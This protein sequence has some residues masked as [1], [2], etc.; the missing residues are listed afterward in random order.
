MMCHRL[1]IS[2]FSFLFVLLSGEIRRLILIALLVGSP[3]YAGNGVDTAY[4]YLPGYAGS[5]RGIDSAYVPP[6]YNK[7]FGDEF[8]T[9][10]L[11][12]TKWWT[13][14]IYAGGYLN[15]INDE[16][17]S[18]LE[19]GN[20]V[21]ENWTLYLKAYFLPDGTLSSGMLRSK[22]TFLG[23]Y[24]EASMRLP[25]A[26]GTRTAFWLNSGC[27]G[28]TTGNACSA[29]LS[30]P[31][32]IDI[33]EYIGRLGGNVWDTVGQ[34]HHSPFSENDSIMAATDPRCAVP[35]ADTTTDGLCHTVNYDPT[36]G[37]YWVANPPTPDG[38]PV[39]MWEDFH[40]W[41]L[42]WTVTD[43]ATQHGYITTYFDG[44][45]IVTRNYNWVYDGGSPAGYAHILLDLGLGGSFGGTFDPNALP[46]ALEVSYVRVYQLP[47]HIAMRTNDIGVDLCPA[48]GGC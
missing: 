24:F 16:W 46:Q 3:A 15:H 45:P 32:E 42:L 39:Y 6:G 1:L 44:K 47:A 2:V 43:Y 37:N 10:N 35:K 26:K 4:G 18:F 21:I 31:P 33:M 36:Y 22:K 11:D 5:R 27:P 28:T 23:G 40:I 34:V 48:S 12:T 38:N 19:S 41:G 17:E 8:S 30:W 9:A 14:Y 25:P 20:H 29:A 13:R 7:V